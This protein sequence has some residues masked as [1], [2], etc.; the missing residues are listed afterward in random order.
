ME[1]VFTLKKDA[2][3][4][5]IKN[6]IAMKIDTVRDTFSFNSSN[7]TN[8]LL[9]VCDSKRLKMNVELITVD[10]REPT[11]ALL[12]TLNALCIQ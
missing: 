11:F 12:S 5:R 3:N 10:F 9:R 7:A 1:D 6:L 4:L 8:D 2:A